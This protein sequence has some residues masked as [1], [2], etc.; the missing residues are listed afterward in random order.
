LR[1]NPSFEIARNNVT[2]ARQ[3]LQNRK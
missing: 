1:L 2:F 3:Q